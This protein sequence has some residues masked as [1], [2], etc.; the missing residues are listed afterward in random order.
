M[1]PLE[2]FCLVEWAW[3]ARPRLP[4][5]PL[6]SGWFLLAAWALT[7][8]EA[9][10]S[11]LAAVLSGN[12]A[13]A[14]PCGTATA[15]MIGWCGLSTKEVRAGWNEADLDAVR[16]RAGLEERLGELP[17]AWYEEKLP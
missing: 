5:L 4:R 8:V 7:G 2:W 15:L 16:A 9:A 13:A 11:V 14:V 17:V 6:L 3:R 12:P 1:S 10:G